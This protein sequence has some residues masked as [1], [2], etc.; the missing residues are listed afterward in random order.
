MHS[1][2]AAGESTTTAFEKKTDITT[3]INIATR[4][5]IPGLVVELQAK[6]AK[7]G[8]N[9]THTSVKETKEAHLESKSIKAALHD[10][11]LRRLLRARETSTERVI[12]LLSVLA[13]GKNRKLNWRMCVAFTS[14]YLQLR[15]LFS[16]SG[17]ESSC[18]EEL[19]AVGSALDTLGNYVGREAM[20]GDGDA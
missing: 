11:A 16:F 4:K 18:S 9:V 10:L 6:M 2:F 17:E 1:Y 5:R 7:L 15:C 19:T 12:N 8:S 13:K 20:L 14:Q 3:A